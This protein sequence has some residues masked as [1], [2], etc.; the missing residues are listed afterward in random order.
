MP[1]EIDRI[2]AAAGGSH[3]LIEPGKAAEIVNVLALRAEGHRLDWDGAENNKVYAEEPSQARGG[4]RVHVLRLHGTIMPRGNMMTSMSGGAS[5]DQFGAAF[6]EAAADSTARAIVMDIDSPGGTA[7]LVPERA[8]K[9]AAARRSGRPII[10]VANTMAASAAYWIAAAA[11]EIV[12]SP[13]GRVGSIG[14]MTQRDNMLGALA[15]AGITRE[16]FSTAPRKIEGHPFAEPLTTAARAAIMAEANALHDM[17]VGDVA[18]WRGVP[19]TTVRADPEAAEAHFGGG[20]VYHAERSVRLGMADRVATF[21]DTLAR[22]VRGGS[23][24]VGTARRRL[25]TL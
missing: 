3:W 24:N 9:I 10:A 22:A 14:V 13:S 6:D 2:L 15:K 23:R 4:G 21:E 18:E 25:S 17:F 5:L 20:R 19:E 1:H 11:D 8:R 7:D 12:V 16:M